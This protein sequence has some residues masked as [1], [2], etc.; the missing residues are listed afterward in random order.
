VIE[1]TAYFVEEIENTKPWLLR[2]DSTLFESRDFGDFPKL[3]RI[4]IVSINCKLN[5]ALKLPT[6][7]VVVDD[8][9]NEV[10]QGRDVSR[11]NVMSID[12][13]QNKIELLQR[14]IKRPMRLNSDPHLV[15]C[16]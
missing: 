15:A 11:L 3:A 7:L 14:L 6:K 12:G 9:S 8:P 5:T 13:I 16:Q 4:V 10:R 2:C 1:I